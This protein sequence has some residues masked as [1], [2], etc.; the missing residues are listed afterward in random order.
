MTR[1]KLHKRWVILTY[2]HNDLD[3][4]TSSSQLNTSSK[5]N[6]SQLHKVSLKMWGFFMHLYAGTSQSPRSCL[7]IAP[8]WSRVTN[9]STWQRNN[10]CQGSFA[11]YHHGT[12]P[13]SPKPCQCSR[14]QL[15]K[16]QILPQTKHPTTGA[17]IL[18][19]AQIYTEDFPNKATAYWNFANKQDNAKWYCKTIQKKQTHKNHPK[20]HPTKTIKS[21][22]IAIQTP[23]LWIN[24]WPTFSASPG[25]SRQV[26][27]A[28]LLF[29]GKTGSP[30]PQAKNPRCWAVFHRK[31]LGIPH[32][33][34]LQQECMRR[35]SKVLPS[36]WYLMTQNINTSSNHHQTYSN[37]MLLWWK[38]IRYTDDIHEIWTALPTRWHRFGQCRWSW[39][40][41]A[42]SAMVMGMW[43]PGTAGHHQMKD[44]QCST[45]EMQWQ[46]KRFWDSLGN[47]RF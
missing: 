16:G 43:W 45:R 21:Q 9:Y 7:L 37:V 41:T 42:A 17:T 34:L 29:T 38:N 4:H 40:E 31:I 32:H 27:K 44:E 36:Q 46:A 14:T 18:K 6:K 23:W 3:H 10:T 26:T 8:R 2:T 19:V 33:H 11:I 25:V 35:N 13:W 1:T 20:K 15:V 30:R 47:Y 12:C 5:H 24:K 39:R 22:S 28:F